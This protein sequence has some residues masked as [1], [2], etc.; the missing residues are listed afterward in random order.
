LGGGVKET[1]ENGTGHNNK[2]STPISKHKKSKENVFLSIN[3]NRLFK[4]DAILFVHPFLD[5]SIVIF[6]DNIS[7]YF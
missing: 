3:L 6:I 5:G 1:G 2:Y 7:F 4:E